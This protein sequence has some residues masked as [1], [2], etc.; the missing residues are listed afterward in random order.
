MGDHWW[1]LKKC[2]EIVADLIQNPDPDLDPGDAIATALYTRYLK[3]IAAHLINI[4]TSVF[5]P[6]ERLGFRDDTDEET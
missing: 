4:A 3:R 2:D 5:N 1:I 6:F